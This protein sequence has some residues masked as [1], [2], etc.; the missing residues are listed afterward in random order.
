ML[1]NINDSDIKFIIIYT[2]LNFFKIATS[3]SEDLRY[4]LIQIPELLHKNYNLLVTKIYKI[5]LII[6]K[7]VIL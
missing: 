4:K 3:I 5:E 7:T 6:M 1:F 2:K